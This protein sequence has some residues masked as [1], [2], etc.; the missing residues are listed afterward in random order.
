MSLA[1]NCFHCVPS[2][3]SVY[4]T[5]FSCFESGYVALVGRKK[6]TNINI[7]ILGKGGVIV[8]F[9]QAF[10][11]CFF[12]FGYILPLSAV[13]VFYALMLRHLPTGAAHL[14]GRNLRAIE[15]RIKANRRITSMIIVVI[16]V[17][18]GGPIFFMNWLSR[19]LCRSFFFLSFFP[20]FN[21][22]F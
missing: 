13:M 14:N 10:Y 19:K 22:A 2:H 6:L 7:I 18:A 12:A 8:W 15:E 11:G 1:L 4:I 5:F 21:F 9:L 17:G 3:F 16:S 20:I